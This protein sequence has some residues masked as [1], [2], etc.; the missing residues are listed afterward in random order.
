MHRS[1]L[2]SNLRF[3]A[4]G[5]LSALHL[6]LLLGIVVGLTF[7]VLARLL[8]PLFALG[9]LI[10]I[11]IGLWVFTL[12]VQKPKLL[13]GLVL[14]YAPVEL[15]VQKW[16]PGSLGGTSR[17]ATEA[18][19]LV[20]LFSLLFHSIYTGKPW[21]RTP[22][23]LPLLLFL[24]ASSA[25]A[26]VNNVPLYAFVLGVRILLRYVALYYLISQL[27]FTKAEI[28]RLL[29]AVLGTGLVVVLI[30]L[31]QAAVGQPVTQILRVDSI[32]IGESETR[33][34][35][36][37]FDARGR[38]IFSTLG[39]YDA[40]GLYVGILLL[41][42]TA[43]FFHYR[44]YRRVMVGFASL[45]IVS[46][47]LSM[48]RTSWVSVYVALWAFALV[49]RNKSI[50]ALLTLLFVVPAALIGVAIS[51][52]DLVQ[53]FSY[54][55]L[56]D[57]N[58][59]TRALE[60]FSPQY[61]DISAFSGGRIYVLTTVNASVFA[62]VP[63]FGFGPGRFGSLTASY[64]GYNTADLLDLPETS[65]R[66]VND[67]NWTVVFGQYGTIGTLAFVGMFLIAMW[68]ASSV[69]RNSGDP[70]TRS[71]A[72][73]S[74]G[75][76]IFILVAALFGP[77]FEQRI[78][79]MYVWTFAALVLVSARLDTSSPKKVTNTNESEAAIHSDSVRSI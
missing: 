61:I 7:V 77:N 66:L 48:S 65:L 43:L 49:S 54:N 46:L 9:A 41:I 44:Q 23:D 68:Y 33:A 51:V 73:S 53:H 1:R 52:P 21:K 15:F 19:L 45:L 59:L 25:S 70:L 11:P 37:I 2:F 55:E 14:C 58:V 28:Q 39:R 4:I 31:A 60:M 18:V 3:F 57:A 71:I 13:V 72:L 5:E 22:L 24:L 12:V 30:G 34:I 78:V 62:K 29:I 10:S 38:Y 27:Q 20:A 26:L 64:L 63:F 40:F 69:Y 74:V 56:A 8:S 79:S 6:A 75:L 47:L 16:L 32:G 17:F 36:G 35:T 76:V 42:I 67:V 50:S